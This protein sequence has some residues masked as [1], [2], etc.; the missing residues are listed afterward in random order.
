MLRET[1]RSTPGE[2]KGMGLGFTF[3]VR[4]ASQSFRRNK[5]RRLHSWA[6]FFLMVYLF[7]FER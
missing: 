2:G 4:C 1:D 5:V 7:L 3:N 6:F